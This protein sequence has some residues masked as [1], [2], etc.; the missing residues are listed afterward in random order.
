LFYV[1][2]VDDDDVILCMIVL[3]LSLRQVNVQTSSIADDLDFLSLA[4][5]P[6]AATLNTFQQ[7]PLSNI[8]VPDD[9]DIFSAPKPAEHSALKIAAPLPPAV[10]ESL[11]FLSLAGKPQAATL[12]TF[13]QTPLSNIGVPDDMD[14]F[15]APLKIAAPLPPAVDESHS[16]GFPDNF[17]PLATPGN[18]TK[19]AVINDDDDIFNP[20]PQ[21]PKAPPLPPLPP[22]PQPPAL[23][24]ASSSD[25]FAA[26]VVDPFAVPGQNRTITSPS[27]DPF[28]PSSSD[29]FAPPISS[30]D[31]F[32]Q[33]VPPSNDP[34]APPVPTVARPSYPVALNPFT[35][36]GGA[37]PFT[38]GDDRSGH[39]SSPFGTGES[40]PRAQ[41]VAAR[42]VVEDDE[43]YGQPQATAAGVGNFPRPDLD[44]EPARTNNP[45]LRIN[46][47]FL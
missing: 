5:K 46:I 42:D 33:R 28:T 37:N 1:Y 19:A 25:P 40:L 43:G 35:A 23:A 27:S 39:S 10:D 31:P 30:S 32:R 8:G 11:D 18:T 12:N 9:M 4:G 45:N 24:P 34:F 20:K 21:P 38:D 29:P 22:Q 7:T 41:R 2:D 16:F 36:G 26:P 13:Q 17:T 47:A 14:I 44:S 15:S 3:T 6:Q